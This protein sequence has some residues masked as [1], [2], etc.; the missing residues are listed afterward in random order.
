MTPTRR[1]KPPPVKS[2]IALLWKRPPKAVEPIPARNLSAGGAPEV[3]VLRRPL[4]ARR[5]QLRLGARHDHLEG[6]GPG[7]HRRRPRDGR[8]RRR[9]PRRAGR[10]PRRSDPDRGQE[11][12][13]LLPHLRRAGLPP[14]A[15]RRAEGDPRPAVRGGKDAGTGGQA[16][17][18]AC[19]EVAARSSTA[20]SAPRRTASTWRPGCRSG[21]GT[22]SPTG[23][24]STPP[25]RASSRRRKQVRRQAE[26]MLA[27]P[28]AKAKLRELP[29]DLAQGRPARRTWPRTRRSSPASTPRSSP[30]CAP[31]WNCSS[32]TSSGP[33]APT[34][35]SCS[36]RKTCSSTAGSRSSTGR[37]CRPMPPSRR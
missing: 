6:V 3:F 33:S 35:A 27:D 32:T 28:R 1:R 16:R 12:P 22:R 26:R 5:P 18:P 34:S 17:R 25:R 20:R 30:T 29:A 7:H 21:C 13:R 14:A 8:L 23:N 31:R 4:P 37:I 36:C 10:Q 11:T 9:A 15:D 24:C 19:A 2:S